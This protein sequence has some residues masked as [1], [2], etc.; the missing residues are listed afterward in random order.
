[1]LFKLPIYRGNQTSFL[2]PRTH[3]LTNKGTQRSCNSFV[4]IMYFLG[5]AWYKLIPNPIQSLPPEIMIPLTK[6]T[7][8]YTNPAH[9]VTS[10]IYS[11]SD[12]NKLRDHITWTKIWTVFSNSGTVSA[13]FIGVIIIIRGIKLIID[14]VI[15]GYALYTVFGW[16]FHLIGAIWDF[17][18]NLLLHL[19]IGNQRPQNQQQEL[20]NINPSAPN[21]STHLQSS[22]T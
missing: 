3:I 6:S 18:T 5:D 4:P 15:H 14:T 22:Q 7:W 11:Q 21:I 16:S 9:L 19:G 13:G 8:R 10:G 20:Q 2:T 12:L 17:V 1:M